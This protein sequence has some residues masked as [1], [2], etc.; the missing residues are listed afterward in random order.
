MVDFQNKGVYAIKNVITGQMYIGSSTNIG[1]RRDKHFSLLKHG[2]HQNSRLQ[3]SA[4]IHGMKAFKLFILEFTEDLVVREQF[5]V[6]LYKPEFNITT[7]VINNTPS[8]ASKKK[9]SETR[10]RLYQEGLK[11]NCAK[12]VIGVHIATGEIVEYESIRKACTA[13]SI[14]KSAVQRV[15]RG[16]YQQMKGYK[17]YFKQQYTDLVKLGELLEKPGE[18]NQQPS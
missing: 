7:D 6:N 13:H 3:G 16:I 17:W 5:F 15:L 8:E 1:G 9:M 11:P 2:K 12:A 4:I 10:L 18:V 14:D